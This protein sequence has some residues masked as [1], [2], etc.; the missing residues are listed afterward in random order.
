MFGYRRLSD[1]KIVEEIQRGNEEALVTLYK[2]NY[3]MVRNFVLR[4]SGTEEEVDDVLQD[5]LIAVWQNVNKEEFI[6]KVKLSTYVMSIVKNQWFKRLKKKSRFT[7]VDEAPHDRFSQE[8]DENSSLDMRIIH[9][10]VREMDEA[11]RKLL[12]YFYFDGLNNKVIADKMGYA[13][14]DTVKSKKYQCFKKLQT[15]VKDQFTKG[16]FFG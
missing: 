15:A 2:E 13:N 12:S 16:D 4:N 5:S 3:T 6:L 14:T 9:E 1:P 10:M 11:C 7:R 8:T